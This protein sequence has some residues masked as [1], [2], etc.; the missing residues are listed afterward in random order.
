MF[1]AAPFVLIVIPLLVKYLNG[2]LPSIGI[3]IAIL[4][5]MSFAMT[6]VTMPLLTRLARRWLYPTK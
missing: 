2:V 3:S 4:L 6:W 1:G 5:V